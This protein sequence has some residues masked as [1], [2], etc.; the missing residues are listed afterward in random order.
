MLQRLLLLAFLALFAVA[1]AVAQDGSRTIS[2]VVTDAS[3]GEPLPGASIVVQGTSTGTSTDIEGEYELDVPGP[4]AVLR[5]SFIGYIAQEETVGDREVIDIALGPDTRE[6]DEVVV[7]GYGSTMQRELTG[8]VSRISSADIEN[9]PATSVEETLQ[10]KSAGVFITQNNGKLGQGIDVQVRGIA[11][12]SADTEPLYVVDGIPISTNNLSSNGAQTNPLADLNFNDIE[13][14]EILKDASAAAIYGARGSNGV[15]LITTKSGKQGQTTFSV[16]TQVGTAAPTNKVDFLNAQEYIDLYTEAAEN[17]DRVLGT[18]TLIQGFIE[19]DL[20]FLTQGLYSQGLWDNGGGP[21]FNWQ[22]TA[23]N[24]SAM[25]YKVDVSASGG[26]E[27]TQFYISGSYTNEEGTLIDNSFIEAQYVDAYEVIDV[28][29][30]VLLA[31]DSLEAAGVP[32]ITDRIRGQAYFLRGVMHFELVRL[33]ARAYVDGDPSTN[34]GVP[35]LLQPTRTIP[36]IARPA[37][38]TV[39]EVY[40]AVISDLTQARDLLPEED[41]P[42][43]DSFVASAMLSRVYLMTENFPR[44]RD[45]A[46]RVISSGKYDLTSLYEQA[47][48]QST[49]PAEYIFAI[50]ISVQDNGS[51]SLGVFYDAEQQ[52]PE[53]QGRGDIFV[54]DQHV[55]RYTDGDVRGDFFYFADANDRFTSKWSTSNT[56]NIPVIRLPEMYLTRAEA[57]FR[58]GTEVGNPPFEDINILRERADL[59]GADLYGA[60]SLTLDDI[61]DERVFELSFEGHRLHDLKRTQRSIGSIP[62]DDPS[63]VYPIPQRELDANPNLTQNPGYGS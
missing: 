35:I 39:Q 16:N 52:D 62:F 5:F 1:P 28:A 46:N 14:I 42:Y 21:D 7:V 9:S 44:A 22:N 36:E 20:D 4:D 50:Q 23:F 59:E 31:A 29:N 15:V 55:A 34:L 18:G 45:E 33:F 51:H 63:L 38:A 27:S 60:A 24:E 47:F 57:N 2:G 10:G 41:A 17:S 25:S 8:N 58:L 43:A 12:I 30:N 37:R 54:T 32:D 56:S 19:S 40:D 61:L 6:L 49:D 26:N 13:S 48:N 11:S 53:G 3:T